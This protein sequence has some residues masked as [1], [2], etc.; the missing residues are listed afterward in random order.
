M[1]GSASW[2]G[3]DRRAPDLDRALGANIRDLMAAAGKG[4]G[5]DLSMEATTAVLARQAKA[6][7][8][9][10]DCFI[11]VVAQE[12]QESF[13]VL[14]AAGSWAEAQLG[15]EWVVTG[16]AVGRAMRCAQLGRKCSAD[17]A[18]NENGPAANDRGMPGLVWIIE[19]S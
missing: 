13:R 17:L 5:V 14:G 6:M 1:D 12:R 18:E 11:A 7:L 9:G 2:T 15:R 4:L 10:V 16:T 19:R 8:S 3:D